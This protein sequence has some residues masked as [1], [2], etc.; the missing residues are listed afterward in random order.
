MVILV[1]DSGCGMP[2]ELLDLIFDPLFTTKD[3][4]QGTGLG[5]S[6]VRNIVLELNGGVDLESEVGVGTTFRVYIPL[7][8]G[9]VAP[10]QPT[11]PS[12]AGRGRLLVVDDEPSIVQLM[13]RGLS[14]LGYT[15]ESFTASIEAREAFDR[16][17]D[18]YDLVLTDF[19]MPK[20]TGLALAHHIRSIRPNLPIL[21]MSGLGEACDPTALETLGI[22]PLIR[23]PLSLARLSTVL[24]ALLGRT[25]DEADVSVPRGNS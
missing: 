23:K 18:R 5:L 22:P 1:R 17:P 19:S 20:L 10:A 7:H 21:V 14:R 6:V 13:R 8:V 9:K 2:P 24:K 25:R 15:I 4:G 12:E 16:D 3:P 11:G